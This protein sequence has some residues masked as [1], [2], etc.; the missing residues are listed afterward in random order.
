M[1]ART[2]NGKE[3]LRVA[4]FFICQKLAKANKIKFAL[5]SMENLHY[6]APHIVQKG[7]SSKREGNAAARWR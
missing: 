4:H 6:P 2:R 3:K 7:S 5:F 1:M